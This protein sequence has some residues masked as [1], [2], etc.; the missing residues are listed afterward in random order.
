MK[1]LFYYLI[2]V[3]VLF[4]GSNFVSAASLP[5]FEKSNYVDKC[6]Y[7]LNTD[8][9]GVLDVSVYV[10][11]KNN[12]YTLYARLNKQFRGHGV[13]DTWTVSDHNSKNKNCPD[14]LI[15]DFNP[16]LADHFYSSSTGQ[17]LGKKD[18]YILERIG[19][20]NF[21]QGTVTSKPNCVIKEAMC[22]YNNDYMSSISC[23]NGVCNS[24]FPSYLQNPDGS[25]YCP[26]TV[27]VFNDYIYVNPKD[28]KFS[29]PTT[30]AS[31]IKESSYII[32][33]DTTQ[34]KI[35][36]TCKFES[37]IL[38][39]LFISIYDDNTF[40]ASGSAIYISSDNI[41]FN[42]NS[43]N[44]NLTCS[45]IPEI[46]DNCFYGKSS[47]TIGTSKVEDNDRKWILSTLVSDNQ[48]NQNNNNNNQNN[49]DVLISCDAGSEIAQIVNIFRDLLKVVTIL[50]PV[51]LVIFGIVDI[52][53]TITSA[54]VDQKKLFKSITK[55]IIAA[56]VIFLIPFII[57]FVV[58]IIPMGSSKWRD[59]WGVDYVAP[60]KTED[61]DKEEG[62]KDSLSEDEKLVKA[63]EL[64]ESISTI[65]HY[66]DYN[67]DTY[68]NRA[69]KSYEA[70]K[71]AVD[72]L[73]NSQ[74]KESLI[75]KLELYN[76]YIKLG[77]SVLSIEA[78]LETSEIFDNLSQ[79]AYDT[80]DNWVENLLIKYR[81][82][83]EGNAKLH[84]ANKI[85]HLR[86][87]LCDKLK[88]PDNK[89][90]SLGWNVDGYDSRN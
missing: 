17:S 58:D 73:S 88:W 47:C 50:V 40:S 44:Q 45:N 51:L 79:S 5:D 38:T 21:F 29:Y 35:R 20:D 32:C 85:Q 84:H 13:G 10:V 64:V 30:K 23:S 78:Q 33:D 68:F 24:A 72:G 56:V 74:E 4:I 82:L 8:N 42:I 60:P 15:Y 65:I 18:E 66:S 16:T 80:V 83:P 52:M 48:N 6:L 81:E 77:Q 63:T 61:E 46:Y 87:D 69:Q 37:E 28:N 89:V 55:R 19:K 70:A 43:S 31:L 12:K 14:Y 11:E 49:I 1:K 76:K 41:K 71:K 75:S 39:P 57:D 2:F 27:E 7:S 67:N 59:C 86:T 9:Y 34:K 62:D 25:F 3:C 90:C 36:E 54:E 22:V 26:E 53:K